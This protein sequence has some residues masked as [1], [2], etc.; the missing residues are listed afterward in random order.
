MTV[1]YRVVHFQVKRGWFL[2]EDAGI[3]VESQAV[4]VIKR[5]RKY[6]R[7]I[8]QKV[9]LNWKSKKGNNDHKFH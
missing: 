2:V 7:Q 4:I 5:V 9:I 1:S 8:L 3:L 6:T